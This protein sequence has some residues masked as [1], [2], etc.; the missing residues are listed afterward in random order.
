M[1]AEKFLRLVKKFYRFSKL[2]ARNSD[3]AEILSAERF[4]IGLFDL[5]RNCQCALVLLLGISKITFQAMGLAQ[6]D[7]HAR[8]L[9]FMADCARQFH[10]IFEKVDGAILI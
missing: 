4:H 9:H 7:Q 3:Q 2:L 10:T 6:I 5:S 8:L 1:S